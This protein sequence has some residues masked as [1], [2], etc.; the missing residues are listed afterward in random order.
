[1]LDWPISFRSVVSTHLGSGAK[2]I[3]HVTKVLPFAYTTVMTGLR[4]CRFIGS[5][6]SRIDMVTEIMY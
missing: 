4:Y 6:L 3:V 2:L 1:L 5:N